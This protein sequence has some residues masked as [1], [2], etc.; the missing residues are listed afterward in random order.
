MAAPDG[1]LDEGVP[2]PEDAPP[3][4]DWSQVASAVRPGPSG[5]Y[6]P[7]AL[8]IG[9]EEWAAVPIATRPGGVLLALPAGALAE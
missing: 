3:A 2:E 7:L 6:A 9:L 8:R 1:A 4:V 5:K